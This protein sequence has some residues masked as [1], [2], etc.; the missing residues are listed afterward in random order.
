MDI[1][2]DENY[3]PTILIVDDEK[4]NIDYIVKSFDSRFKAKITTDS[5]LVFKIL[6]K[7]KIDLILLDI[8]MPGIN[9]FEIAKKLK[10]D[11]RYSNIPFI[12]LTSQS[13]TDSLVQGFE[14]GAI[15]YITKPFN[16]A[17]LKARINTHVNNFILQQR[18]KEQQK[19]I[20][21]QSKFAAI[22]EMTSMLAHQWRQPLNIISLIAQEIT[23]D[24]EMKILSDDEYYRKKELLLNTLSDLS[25]TIE[26]FVKYYKNN[27]TP[28]D[29]NVLVSLE[30]VINLFNEIFEENNIK[31][32]V[33]CQDELNEFTFKSLTKDIKQIFINIIQNSIEA[34]I[35]E[36]NN[37]DNEKEY[38]INV[39]LTLIEDFINIEIKDNAGGID[40][41]IIDT[42]FEPYVSTKENLNGPGLGLYSVKM[43]IENHL[44]GSINAKN[45]SDGVVFTIKIKAN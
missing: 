33:E 1:N 30:Q 11:E 22:G 29:V 27:E 18:V 35:K 24:R 13:E 16:L 41:K 14:L 44:N 43:M 23:F 10:E 5:K 45:T 39:K 25:K 6:E 31:I 40:T 20:L 12:F 37:S 19:E 3:Q 2:F 8:Q 28:K 34:I 7:N 38:F 32:K 36:K 4:I 42:V 15:D 21:I 26:T 17:E 9:G